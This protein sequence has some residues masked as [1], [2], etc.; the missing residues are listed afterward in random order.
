MYIYYICVYIYI[1][2]IRH[3][4]SSYSL[5]TVNTKLTQSIYSNKNN[6][7][8]MC[9]VYIGDNENDIS[10]FFCNWLFLISECV[11]NVQ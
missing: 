2:T 8:Y 7:Y 11:C 9:K 10:A 4:H 5:L 3:L 6:M 1:C